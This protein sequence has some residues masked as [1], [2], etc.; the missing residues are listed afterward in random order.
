MPTRRPQ[1]PSDRQRRWLAH[2]VACEKS[3]RRLSEY[4]S[5]H[6]LDL[7]QLYNWNALLRRRGLLPGGTRPTA[8]RPGRPIRGSNHGGENVKPPL[9][10]T[11]VRLSGGD[12]VP[13][14]TL[15]VRFPNGIILETTATDPSIPGR[16]LLSFLAGLP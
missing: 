9:G 6:N 12:L 4:A 14:P 2:L 10:F 8:A 13:S 16:D 11:A 3:G 5:E 15:L 1:E 7:Q